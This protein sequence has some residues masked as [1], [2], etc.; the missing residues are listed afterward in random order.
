MKA[1]TE[2]NPKVVGIDGDHRDDGVRPG[3][4]LPQPQPVQLRATPIDARF[5]NAA[6]ISKGTEVMEAGV[7]V[8]SVSSVE[9]HG[10]AVD[11]QLRSNRSVVLPH[12]DDGRRRG[13]DAPGRRRR[14]P[15][16][17]QRVGRS[18]EAGRAHHRHLGAD[19]VLR[20]AEHGALA[21]LQ[22]QRQGAQQ[23]RHVLGGHHQGQ[24]DAGG[25]DHLG[26]R[27]ADDDR[28]SALRPG[29][30]ADRL[31]EH[32]VIDAGRPGPAVA[33]HRQ[34]PRHGLDRPGRQQPGPVQPDHQRRQPWRARPT[35][36]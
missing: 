26:A 13:R 12:T 28:R 16:A 11:A 34:Q 9:V 6:G 21:A 18:P 25:P 4:P 20:A 14:D 30:A 10:N 36:W 31:G 35:A 32:A 1:V 33:L 7:N 29:L 22:D 19:R 23:P 8:G 24:A 3:D 15:E 27:R 17:G 2:R 5:T